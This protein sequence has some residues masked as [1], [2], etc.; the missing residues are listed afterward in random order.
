[1]TGEGKKSSEGEKRG[2]SASPPSS[3]QWTQ[4]S[5]QNKMLT[6]STAH[7]LPKKSKPAG[8]KKDPPSLRLSCHPEGGCARCGEAPHHTD[9]GQKPLPPPPPEGQ[10][11][12]P[13][14][15]ARG[16]L[17]LKWT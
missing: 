10:S 3:G 13:V 4:I 11:S 6:F 9:W 5:K 8:A 14:Q 12:S 16:A 1:M 7:L 2:A 17:A 15:E